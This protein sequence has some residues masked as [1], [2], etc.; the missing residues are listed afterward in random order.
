MFD[1]NALSTL[2][3]VRLQPIG[4]WKPSRFGRS[5]GA[6]GSILGLVGVPAAILRLRVQQTPRV[7]PTTLNLIEGV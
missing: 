7:V 1:I 5:Y 3:A 2:S 4:R 6:A